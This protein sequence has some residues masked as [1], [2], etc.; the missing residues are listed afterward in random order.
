MKKIFFVSLLCIYFLLLTNIQS[1]NAQRILVY[2]NNQQIFTVNAVITQYISALQ[3]LGYNTDYAN[4]NGMPDISSYD[5]VF[6]ISMSASPALCWTLGDIQTVQNYL[7]SGGKMFVQFENGNYQSCD[8]QKLDVLNSFIID[9]PTPATSSNVAIGNCNI[10]GNLGIHQDIL[11]TPNTITNVAIGCDAVQDFIISKI[12][13][14]SSLSLVTY[15]GGSAYAGI[16]GYGDSLYGSAFVVWS[17]VEWVPN[18]DDKLVFQN[19]VRWLLKTLSSN[20]AITTPIAGDNISNIA[21]SANFIL[22]GTGAIPN[23][24]IQVYL[25]GQ[26]GTLLVNAVNNNDGTWSIGPINI[27]TLGNGAATATV[28]E[29]LGGS[30]SRPVSASFSLAI[31]ANNDLKID[32]PLPNTYINNAMQTAVDVSGSGVSAT[33]STVSVSFIGST[34]VTRAATVNPDK[35][36]SVIDVDISSLGDG[37]ITIKATETDFAGNLF[38][39][40]ISVIKDISAPSNIQITTPIAGDNKVNAA[41]QSAVVVTGT[42]AQSLSSVVTIS[43]SDGVNTIT[44]IATVTNTGDYSIT[45]ADI[46]SLQ[47]GPITVSVV[48]TDLA[49]NVSPTVSTTITKDTVSPSTVVINTPIAG[50]NYVNN[51]EKTSVV[52]SGSGVEQ[53]ATVQVTFTDSSSNSI[54]VSATNNG[55]GT[56]TL[57]ATDISSL[58]DGTITVTVAQ[59]DA[60]GNL[61]SSSTTT[62]AKDSSTPSNITITAPQDGSY[63]NNAQK[64]AVVVSGTSGEVSSTVRVTFTDSSTNTLSITA[65]VISGVYNTASADISLLSDGQITI[66]A[67]ETDLAGNSGTPVSITVTKD[68]V[69][70]SSVTVTSPLVGE[71][72]N[73]AEKSTVVV[74]GS[75]VEF[76]TSTVIVTFTDSSSNSITVTATNNGD[77]TFTVPSTDI[78][79]LVDG[80]ITVSVTQT[81]LSGNTSPSTDVGVIKDAITPASVTINTPIAGDNVVNDAEKTSVVISGSGVEQTA[82]VQV[83]FTDSSSNSITVS[84]T[85]NGDGTY[86]LPAT[87][88]SSLVDGTITVTV[89]QT[90]AA[91]NLGSS[92]T[93]TITK[94]TV[95]PSPIAINTPIAGD[96]VVN[97]A[98]KTSVVISG[99]GVEQT[100]TVQVTFTDSSSNSITVTAT[101][102]G[103]GTY[104]LPATDI[105]SLVDGTITVTVAQTDA[106]GNLGSSSTTTI[107]KLLLKIHPIQV[108]Y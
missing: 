107:T 77:G 88:I 39:A 2:T 20:I 66:T 78:S 37:V 18:F 54:T 23:S 26:S 83:T 36:Y 108:R 31:N 32:S 42:T 21:E 68:T 15:S 14:D 82:T 29:I 27:Q 81:D 24:A 5:V 55:D 105:S 16:W 76:P 44:K 71:M 17:D 85:N 19:I 52:I 58:V 73:N 70:P 95:S 45:P 65:S 10:N 93:I 102:N 79:S 9:N 80:A 38:Y 3:S 104:T 101:N 11:T 67:V 57:P 90:D 97:D 74:T 50:D 6:D 84:A 1:L 64:T 86:T 91:G 99:S 13:A 98:E 43:F 56:Y 60:A 30:S 100:A 8:Q 63:I 22:T 103:D 61:G 51:A 106:A 28:V 96:N 33:T 25:V 7:R 46:S 34:T 40:Q 35:S 47:E 12:D 53:T 4:Q 49:G 69:I 89:A 62:F 94:D 87:D 92:S 41:E 75:G 48:E 72:I 59:T